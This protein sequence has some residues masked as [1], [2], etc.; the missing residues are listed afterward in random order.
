MTE[1]RIP[2]LFCQKGRIMSRWFITD[3]NIR[4]GFDDSAVHI[5]TDEHL[6]A[7]LKKD[8]TAS[9]VLAH[10]ILE[11][12]RILFGKPLN[13][14]R[15]SLAAEIRLHVLSHAFFTALENMADFKNS[16]ICH[17]ICSKMIRS[18]EVIDC[19][20]RQVDGNRFVFDYVSI[21]SRK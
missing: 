17:R 16:G 10:A 8:R 2:L 6:K 9:Y 20:E 15:R 3:R 18:A 7:F 5:V 14:S 19:G 13:I 21:F 4:I 1:R 11:R 12:Y